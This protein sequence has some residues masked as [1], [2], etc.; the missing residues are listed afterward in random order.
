MQER[1]KFTRS[2]GLAASEEASV[3]RELVQ[4][5]AKAPELKKATT[6]EAIR[7]LRSE[8]PPEPGTLRY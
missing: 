6:E 1:E 2:L 8:P 3:L 7:K 4:L 5:A